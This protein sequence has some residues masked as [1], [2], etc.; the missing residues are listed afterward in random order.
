PVA[1]LE[2]RRH[3][4]TVAPV[5]LIVLEGPLHAVAF[6]GQSPARIAAA[7]P[8]VVRDERLII[9]LRSDL[10]PERNRK[11]VAAELKLRW[12]AQRDVVI[13]RRTVGGRA[14]RVN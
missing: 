8:I 11:V 4:R 12:L 9:I 3:M 10:C 14:G 7:V 6:S 1:V 13:R 5:G 2:L